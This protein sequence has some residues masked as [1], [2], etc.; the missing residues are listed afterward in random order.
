MLDFYDRKMIEKLM[1]A[2]VLFPD[3]ADGGRLKVPNFEVRERPGNYAL[4][5]DGKYAGTTH[6]KTLDGAVR[7]R[8]VRALQWMAAQDATYDVRRVSARAVIDHRKKMVVRQGLSGAAVICSTLDALEKTLEIKDTLQL[9]HL[10]DDWVEESEDKFCEEYAYE[11]FHNAL[12]YFRTGIR[13]FTK[14]ES[15]AVYLPFDLP[16]AAP[17]KVKVFSE[18]EIATIRRWST[19]EETFVP[20]KRLWTPP[21]EPLTDVERRDRRLVYRQMFLGMNYGSR[22]GIYEGLSHEPHDDGGFFDLANAKF[23]RVPPGKEVHSNKLAPSVDL[24]PDSVAELTRWKIEDK[25][26]PWVFPTMDGG[27]L[28]YDR[29]AVIFASRLAELGIKAT[30][31]TLR[32][33][34]ISGMIDRGELGPTIASIAGISMRMMHDRYDHRDYGKVQ[35]LGHGSMGKMF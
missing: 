26:C 31:H 30:G 6:E 35:R 17:G 16:P 22:S 7:Y 3:L 9:R 29:Q 11:Y 14:K 8:N 10:T 5:I 32:H 23:H 12:K 19:G 20:K 1:E 24:D 18:V 25:G 21:C 33:S 15:G 2:A 28:G 13:D 34:Y 4:F 27:P